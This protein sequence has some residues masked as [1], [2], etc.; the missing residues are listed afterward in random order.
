MGAESA[1]LIIF[2]LEIEGKVDNTFQ[3]IIFETGLLKRNFIKNISEILLK[4][5]I[6]NIIKL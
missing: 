1:R 3:T 4:K 6:F 5:H 2:E